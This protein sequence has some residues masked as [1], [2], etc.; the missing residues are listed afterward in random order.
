MRNNQSQRF[1]A[2][3][4]RMAP[5]SLGPLTQDVD[6]LSSEASQHLDPRLSMCPTQDENGKSSWAVGGTPRQRRVPSSLGRRTRDVY[7]P[8]SEISQDQNSRHQRLRVESLSVGVLSSPPSTLRPQSSA[9]MDVPDGSSDSRRGRKFW[10]REYIPIH[11]IIVFDTTKLF[12]QAEVLACHPWPNTATI[13]NMISRTWIRAIETRQSE[14]REIYE[15]SRYASAV[16]GPTKEPDEISKEIVSISE[17]E[18][19]IADNSSS[20]TFLAET[21]SHCLPRVFR[22]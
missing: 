16:K 13:E 9:S 3:P 10:K 11:N 18:I 20:L 12:L 6:N 1:E 15:G 7:N 19:F 17:S 21:S 2:P 5:L 14:R 4:Q 8:S 22:G